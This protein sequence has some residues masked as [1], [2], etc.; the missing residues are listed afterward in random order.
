MTE[1]EKE[2]LRNLNEII[3]KMSPE[4]RMEFI[5]FAE[6]MAFMVHRQEE[7]REEERALAEM[8]ATTG[9]DDS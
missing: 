2:K 9:G 7:E 5:A 6:G 1:N 4:K 8:A 3:P